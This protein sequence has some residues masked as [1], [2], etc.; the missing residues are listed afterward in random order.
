MTVKGATD[1]T[2][3]S[4][5]ELDNML[6]SLDEAMTVDEA[7]GYIC[8]L[9]VSNQLSNNN[10]WH[11]EIIGEQN[12]NEREKCLSLLELIKENLSVNLQN[13]IIFEPL[14]IEIEEED[15]TYHDYTGWCH[16]FMYGLSL[17]D[18]DWD[19]IP[20]HIK[21]LISPISRLALTDEDSENDVSDDEFEEM[22]EMISGSVSALYD[23]WNR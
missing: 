1:I 12:F 5:E 19:A 22:I 14:F 10:H 4:L 18:I 6:M 3:Q 20:D 13:E 17:L 8:S 16:G 2:E 21:D 7:H 9:I 15:Y 23:Y 11:Q